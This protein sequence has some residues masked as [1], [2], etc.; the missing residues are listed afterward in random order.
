MDDVDRACRMSGADEF[1]QDKSVFPRGYQTVV[2]E[3]GTKLSG[4]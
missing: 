1:I 4:G 3:K 2:G